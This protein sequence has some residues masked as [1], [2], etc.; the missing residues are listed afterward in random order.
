[1]EQVGQLFTESVFQVGLV[2]INGILT[3]PRQPC[4][5]PTIVI[6]NSGLLHHIGSCRLSV[7][8]SRHLASLGYNTIR[9]DFAG[10]GDSPSRADATVSEPQKTIEQLQ[11]V[12]SFVEKQGIASEFLVGGLCSAADGA[13]HIGVVDKRVIGIFQIDPYL[14]RTPEY[15]LRRYFP[16]RLNPAAAVRWFWRKLKSASSRSNEPSFHDDSRFK[17]PQEEVS[18]G[19]QILIDRKVRVLVFV[20]GEQSMLY[21]YSRQFYDMFRR[22]D[23]GSF[24]DFNYRKDSSHMMLEPGQREFISSKIVAWVQQTAGDH[25]N[26]QT[27]P[28]A[29]HIP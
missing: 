25:V 27:Q 14:F 12:F 16:R 13:F 24:L 3:R 10:I 26:R 15:Y 5:G 28:T 17:L 21:N 6:L 22:V 9:F 20:T 29:R 8:I 2:P 23:F 4:N 11:E 1:M 18:T 7:S 19:Y